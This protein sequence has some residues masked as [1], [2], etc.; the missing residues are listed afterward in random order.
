MSTRFV[1]SCVLCGHVFCVRRLVSSYRT[2]VGYGAL[3]PTEEQEK[4]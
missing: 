4:V 3:G 2:T 1:L